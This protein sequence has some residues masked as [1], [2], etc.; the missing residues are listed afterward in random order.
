MRSVDLELAADA[1]GAGLLADREVQR[2][3]QPVLGLELAR[4]QLEGA[5]ARHRAVAVEQLV[6]AQRQART[7]TDGLALDA[8]AAV[9][10]GLGQRQ[11]DQ[12][13]LDAVDRAGHLDAVA[14]DDRRAVL[15]RE[16][17]QPCRRAADR[18]CDLAEP[19][20]VQVR[21]HG[22]PRKS[23]RRGA[24]LVV[25]DAVRVPGDGGEAEEI[26]LVRRELG[27]ADD[28][29]GRPEL[30]HGAHRSS[31]VS[32]QVIS[33]SPSAVRK[34]RSTSTM[35]SEPLRPSFVVALLT[36]ASATRSTP[37]NASAWNCSACPPPS[38]RRPEPVG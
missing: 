26:D 12:R 14:C 24:S 38:V 25:V 23:F 35:S 19:R 29:A 31:L 34:R 9:L 10:A 18:A 2:A 13:P 6:A 7:S 4:G 33:S 17:A 8:D 36:S 32:S 15:P 27:R 3:P 20:A 1:G 30:G 37:A 28:R 5:D 11:A 16:R 21:L 22:Q